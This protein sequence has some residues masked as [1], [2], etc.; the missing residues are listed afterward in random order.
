MGIKKRY[1]KRMFNESREREEMGDYVA[2][3]EILKIFGQDAKKLGRMKEVL[4]GIK[5]SDPLVYHNAMRAM[6]EVLV[7]MAAFGLLA[8]IYAFGIDDD[9]ELGFAAAFALNR[10]ERIG[11]EMRTYTP[12]GMYDFFL[13]TKKD[14]VATLSKA[15]D[16]MSFLRY[17][18]HDAG[19]MVFGYD[20]ARYESGRNSGQSKTARAAVGTL[21]I[22]S[23]FR[24]LAELEDNT[25]TYSL[26][27]GFIY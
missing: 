12:L 5:E 17:G 20:V 24:R 6:K 3:L 2:A 14:P 22:L 10:T 1:G 15:E 16:A 7:S 21:P 11:E 18:V 25:R 13:Q 19:A 27:R 8:A 4:Q 26:V 23:H 9:D